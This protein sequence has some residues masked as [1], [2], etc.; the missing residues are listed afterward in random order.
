ME[1]ILEG[2]TK[3]AAAR[4]EVAGTLLNPLNYGLGAPAAITGVAMGPYSKEKKDNAD[5]KSWSNALIP[6]VGPYRLG[7]RMAGNGLS[8]EQ[9]PGGEEDIRKKKKK[10]NK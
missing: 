4:S 3:R 6:A 2:F 10:K 8:D 5:R 7:R 1:K 9:R